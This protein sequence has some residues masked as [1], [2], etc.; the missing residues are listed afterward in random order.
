[1]RIHFNDCVSEIKD[2]KQQLALSQQQNIDSARELVELSCKFRQLHYINR[3]V[4]CSTCKEKA[5]TEQNEQISV[6]NDK[7]VLE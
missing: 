6:I 3:S 4:D 2:L 5:P 1:M 7:P